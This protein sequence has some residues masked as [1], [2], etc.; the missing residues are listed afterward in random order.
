AVRAEPV[1]REPE[2]EAEAEPPLVEL[3]EALRHLGLDGA[4]FDPEVELGEAELQ[5]PG[6]VP[7]FPDRRGE[8]LPP[9]ARD[10]GA[11]RDVLH[12]CA[13]LPVPRGRVN[14]RRFG[15]LRRPGV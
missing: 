5:E 9:P 7:P 8:L 12:A 3:G 11:L 10:D 14:A 2:L 15:G 4:A 13:T 6:V 1:V